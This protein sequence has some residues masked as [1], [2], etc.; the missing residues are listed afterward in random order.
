MF[1]II[2]H[3]ESVNKEIKN[4]WDDCFLFVFVANYAKN[5][6]NPF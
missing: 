6:I 3:E 5:T 4:A 2:D 1:F